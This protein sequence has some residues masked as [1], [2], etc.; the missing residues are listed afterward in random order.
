MINTCLQPTNG[1]LYRYGGEEFIVLFPQTDEET[2]Y[3]HA[4]AIRKEVERV[5]LIEENTSNVTISIGINSTIPN[6]VGATKQFIQA[7]DDALYQAKKSGRNYVQVF[8]K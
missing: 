8:H 6:D 1:T 7:A 2:A 5:K 4:E 3:T